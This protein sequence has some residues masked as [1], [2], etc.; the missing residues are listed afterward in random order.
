MGNESV[1]PMHPNP[2][3]QAALAYAAIG[4]NVLPVWWT[5]KEEA[6]GWSCA[7]GNPECKSQ[8]KHP[9]GKIAPWGQNSASTDAGTIALW[10]DQYPLANI[11]VYLEPSELCAVDIDPRNGGLQTIEDIEAKYGPL[12]SDLLQLTGGGGEHRVFKLPRNTSLPGKLGQ[13]VDVKANGYIMLEP[14]NHISGGTYSWEASSDPRDGVIASPMPDWMRDL[15][16]P[17]APALDPGDTG[18]ARI[19]P[20][21]GEVK[22]ELLQAL[23]AIPSDERNT[24]VTVGMALHSVGDP[25]WAYDVWCQWSA[26]S[27]KYDCVDQMRVWRSF[28]AQGLEGITYKSIFG[29]AK[30][31]GTVVHSQVIAP[32]TEF[33]SSGV[34]LAQQPEEYPVENALLMPPG[35]LGTV[36]DWIKATAPKPQPQF[37]VQTAI[38]FAATVLG[39]RYCTNFANWPSLYML[40]IGLSASGKEYGKTASEKLLEACGLHHLIGPG[41][42]SSDAGVQ[43]TLF[44]QPSHLAVIDEFHRVLEQASVKNNSRAQGAIRAL[45]EV[46][47]RCD[48]T[49]RATGYSTVG[50]KAK[51][52]KALQERSVSNPA[53]TLL[54]MAIP[55]FW[56][57]IGSA[58]ARDG[59]LNRFLIV[60]S[61]IGRQV[62]QFKPPLP[63]PQA[64]IDWASAM[65]AAT[66]NIVDADTNPMT[67]TPVIIP[68][69]PAA[70]VLFGLF[71]QECLSLMDQHEEDGLAEMFGRSNEIAMRLSLILALGR[72]ASVVSDADAQWAIDYVKT[73]ALRSVQRLKTCMADGDFEAAKKQVLN[74]LVQ[75]GERGL[76][77]SDINRRSRLFRGMTQRQQTELLNSLA[78]LQQA[79]QMQFPTSSGRGRARQAWVATEPAE[80]ET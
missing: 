71:S 50:L 39:R 12:K 67:I 46:W 48:G 65:R 74:L 23:V 57:T 53:L 70:M 19:M 61:T 2:R 55:S 77:P 8:A 4:W 10:W 79:Q 32:P 54:S 40:N 26:R 34:V 73:Y 52:A 33:D 60:E 47:G 72:S 17:K 14:S 66:T 11:A 7:C 31:H 1:L 76:T 27:P 59:F 28:N 24:W 20:I 36:A 38:A 29:L 16:A 5:L 63:V 56:E 43:S 37:A 9:I 35:I 22:A 62:G 13:G 3:L 6:G 78:Y 25:N 69:A 75:S 51:D 41:G 64:V 58:A 49:M 21:S 30:E 45:I 15:T 80:S 18:L 68:I 42:Y 44:T